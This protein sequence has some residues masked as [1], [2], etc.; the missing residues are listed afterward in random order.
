MNNPKID[1]VNDD[2]SFSTR[3]ADNSDKQQDWQFIEHEI[4]ASVMRLHFNIRDGDGRSQQ[5]LGENDL[6]E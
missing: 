5:V 6:R 4:P 1:R 3:F 2:N